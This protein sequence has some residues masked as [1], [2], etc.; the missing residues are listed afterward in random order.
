[1]LSAVCVWT[2]AQLF[3]QGQTKMFSL[4]EIIPGGKDYWKFT[5]YISERFMWRGDELF[6]LKGDSLFAVKDLK[7][8]KNKEFVMTISELSEAYSIQFDRNGMMHFRSISGEGFY[9][10]DKK[11]IVAYFEYPESSDNHYI[12]PNADHLAYTRGNSLFVMD[13]DGK[14]Q[15]VAS[16][17][18]EEISFGRVVHRNEFGIYRGIFW[19]ADGKKIAYYR[20]DETMVTDYPLV[21]ISARVGSVEKIK[22][23]MAGMASHEVTLEVFDIATRSTAKVK[24][25]GAKD[26]Y[27][28]NIAFSPDSR[29]VYI[30]EINREQNQMWLNRY[31]A[32]TGDFDKTLFEER[33]ERYVEP[34]DPMIFL[35]SNPRQF[36]WQSNRDGYKHIYLY[37]TD[38]KLIRQLTKGTWEVTS[39]EG[40]DAKTQ[41]LYFT[42]TNPTPMERHAYSVSLRNG[43]MK[44]LTNNNGINTSTVSKS[45]KYLVAKYNSHNNPGKIDLIDVSS[46]KALNL[47]AAKNP[48]E[49]YNV[50]TV[51]LGTIKAADGLTDLYYRMVKPFDFDS[52]KQYPV[53]IY[54][55][56]GPHSQMVKDSWRYGSGGWEMHMAQKGY[57]VFVMDNRGTSYRGKEFEQVIHRRLGEAEEADQLEGVKFLHSL[58]FVDKNRMGVHGWSFG[59]FMTTK[60][61]L[62]HPDIFKVGVAGGPVMDWSLYEVMYGERY[63]DTPS[64]NPDGYNN[65]NLT[66]KADKLKSRLLLIHDD[67]DRTVVMQHTLRF[68]QAC[69]EAGSHPDLYVYPGHDHNVIGKDRVH[70][71]EHITRYFDD[72]LK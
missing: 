8:P 24:T 38:G 3:A 62:N 41:N 43:K 53:A 34:S 68:L 70:L 46:N 33:D 28:T 9:D 22:Y 16:E 21:D 7:S 59:G 1:M 55:Y 64:E 6:E 56:G 4:E 19:S 25:T 42:S 13:R 15:V 61:V 31:N 49:D 54:V 32:S 60:L 66:L 11:R 37:D 18:N 51:E 5:P 20:M 65:N 40:F 17:E 47:I 63:M 39:I 2:V 48:L 44:R 10:L 12:S 45:G 14:E 36:I 30:A 67:E 29:W 58:P 72:F 50:P 27:L 57:I 71:H 23:P 52:S 26:H 35:P 69:V